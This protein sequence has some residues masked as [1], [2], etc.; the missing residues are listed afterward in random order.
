MA[1]MFDR[2]E[3]TVSCRMVSRDELSIIDVA[4]EHG[5]CSNLALGQGME[6]TT[7][8]NQ[9]D[10]EFL[11]SCSTNS[12]GKVHIFTLLLLG[13]FFSDI[14]QH[15]VHWMQTA[16]CIKKKMDLYHY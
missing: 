13:L 6:T 15:V 14:M 5:S 3:N 11:Q 7:R 9:L 16:I 10:G 1:V 8:V 2:S 12:Q 4:Q